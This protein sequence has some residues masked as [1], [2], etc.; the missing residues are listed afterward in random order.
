[1]RLCAEAAQQLQPALGSHVASLTAG[2][3]KT[4]TCFACIQVVLCTQPQ[5]LC[6]TYH[7]CASTITARVAVWQ[8]FVGSMRAIGGSLLARVLTERASLASAP[9][10]PAALLGLDRWACSAV[11]GAASQPRSGA[12]VTAGCST[13]DRGFATNDAATSTSG[14]KGSFMPSWI[15]NLF[16][17]ALLHASP[18]G[19][20]L[21]KPP[22]SR[23]PFPC[24]MQAAS[25]SQTPREN[26]QV[27]HHSRSGQ[28][29]K[30]QV[31]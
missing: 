12:G 22:S 9:S 4:Q 30:H 7:L 8:R 1:V 19:R 25:T 26:N 2:G 10:G 28:L 5:P 21:V 6:D 17:S 11:A 23:T 15:R 20:P 18:H 24:T 29:Q 16:P 27:S 14:S 3:V 13:S 31:L